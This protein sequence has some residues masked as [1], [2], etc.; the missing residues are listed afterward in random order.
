MSVEGLGGV[1]MRFFVDS[2]SGTLR[3][4]RRG[5]EL[6][7]KA[8]E[9]KII[10]PASLGCHVPGTGTCLSEWPELAAAKIGGQGQ[11]EG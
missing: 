3:G 4:K 9:E 7:V 11:A 8:V 1:E 5:R 10:M 6:L 2:E